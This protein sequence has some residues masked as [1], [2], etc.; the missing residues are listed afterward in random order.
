M[1]IFSR[2]FYLLSIIFF[3]A[4]SVYGQDDLVLRFHKPAQIWE[5]ALPIGNGRVGAMVFGGVEEDHIQFNEETLWTNG[6]RNYNKPGAYTYLDS[7]RR[8]LVS[9]EQSKAEKLAMDKFMGEKSA[10]GDVNQ[11]LEKIKKTREEK[12]NPSTYNFN[13]KLWKTLQVPSYEGWETLGLEAIDGAIWFRK[14]ITLSKNQSQKDWILDL[15][16][17]RDIDYT[18]VNGN[19][20]GSQDNFDKIRNYKIP[21]GL[22]REGKNI[23]AIQ[24]INLQGKG[25]IAGYKDTSNMIGLKNNQEKIVLN[26]DWKYFIQDSNSPMTG[27]FQAAYQPFG[28]IKVIFPHK[29]ITKY[30]RT[31]D[32][33]NAEAKVVYTYNNTLY[34][35]TYLASFPHNALAIKYEAD[36][37]GQLSFDVELSSKHEQQQ[38]KLID[39]QTINLKVRVKNGVLQGD[40]ILHVKIEGGSI[41][42]QDNKL[43]VKEA[44]TATLY[45]TAATNFESYDKVSANSFDKAIDFLKNIQSTSFEEV[46]Q[47][48][49]KD[50][51][52]LFDG[53]S[54]HLGKQSAKETD[55]RLRD[56]A[57]EVDPSFAALYVQFGRYLLIASSREGTQPANLQGIWN[58]LL[59]PSWD[60]KYTTN[61]NLEMN[62]WPTEVLNLSNL[63]QPLFKLIR[64]VSEKGKETAKNYYNARGWVLHHNTDIWRG[65][66]PI[67]NSNHGIWPTGGAW[68]VQHIWESYLYNQDPTI[69]KEN[70]DVIKGATLFFKDFLTPHHKTAELVTNPSNS[71]EHGGLVIGPAMDSQLVRNLFRIYTNVSSILN[72]DPDLRD[73]IQILLPKI[74]KD[75]IGRYGQLQEWIEDV[76]DVKNKHRHISHLWAL[77]PGNEIN[78][79]ETPE[80]W[81][82]AKQ[83]LIYRGDEGTGWSLAWKINFWARLLNEQKSLD[84]VKMLLRP[85]DKNGGSYPNLFDA[86]PPFQIDGNFGG[87]AGIIEMMIQSN[88]KYIHLL[89]AL[90]KDFAFGEIKGVKARGGF[91]IDFKW[92]NSKIKSLKVKSIAGNVLNLKHNTIE[93]VYNTEKGNTY[94]FDA[95]LTLIK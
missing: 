53:F 31:L 86:H 71:P 87:A 89:P 7:I 67:N 16:K 32:L 24:V 9:G 27:K 13:D 43:R 38:I 35:R 19:L 77:H 73:S 28:D 83:S 78:W 49:Q 30:E 5:E 39:K 57:K 54:I 41:S 36:K 58:H 94:I 47:V 1:F 90:S 10:Q 34:R 23:I 93:K 61:I 70:Y 17:V 81:N 48:H 56:F 76:D 88:T 3:H 66:A 40:A 46:R 68:L 63:H 2:S 92:E 11:W 45:L 4:L 65:T 18:Y 60:S 59:E 52:T 95:N 26:G 64:E 8:L 25:G 62:Y 37:S 82:A 69:L 15:N 74:A 12:R 85:A 75:K 51:K 14:E 79:L 72:V 55:Q 6:P 20:I 44:N 33:A 84:L 21:K 29:Q 42:T 22:L 91:I 80:L 50:Y